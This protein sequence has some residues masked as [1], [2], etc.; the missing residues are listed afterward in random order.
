M[1]D[2]GLEELT[3][4]LVRKEYP[5]AKL[6]GSGRDG[7]IDVVSDFSRPPARG[8]QSKTSSSG[9]ASWT[10]CRASLKAA[11]EGAF[12][13]AHYTYVFSHRLSEEQRQ[14]WLDEFHP[15]QTAK[16]P[17]LEVLDYW[18]DLASRVEAFPEILDWIT[19]G[20]LGA[21]VRHTLELAT[22]GGVNPLASAVD[23]SEGARGVA[24]HAQA[25]G[26]TDPRFAY[27]VTGREAD[28]ADRPLRNRVARF[29][30][31][32]SD[33]DALPRFTLSIRDGDA[34]D[35][36]T[37][38]PRSG[39]DV[40]APQPWFADTE[41]GVRAR[42]TA[43][44]SLARGRA[45]TLQGAHVGIAGGHI[46]DRFT[47]WSQAPGSG[48]GALEIGMSE[49]LQLTVTLTLS[50]IGT[51]AELVAM[52]QV[53]PLPGARLGYAGAVGGAVVAIDLRDAEPPSAVG[54]TEAGGWVEALFSVTLAVQDES[55]DDA[56]RGLGLARAFAAAD[57]M[58]FD[59][60]GLLPTAG[61]DVEGQVPMEREASEI[62]EVA[63]TVA[64]ALDALQQRDGRARR[65]PEAVTRR[66]V[67]RAE[68]VLDLLRDG[69]IRVDVGEQFQ[70][71]LPPT[72]TL[73]DNLDR[74]QRIVAELPPIA[75]QLTG[76]QVEQTVE[77]AE[78]VRITTTDHGTLA[79]E[80]RAT[81]ARAQM[82]RCLL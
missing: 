16:Y 42:A 14:F 25:I 67:V 58:H 19:D 27:G 41:G 46:P 60:P 80:Y 78:P 56:M 70:V 6:T 73:D 4:R 62:W 29:T 11:M 66:D 20:A 49:P 32:T 12:P 40:T 18:D 44:A 69:E 3:L 34:V 33:R 39:V 61:Y 64:A 53:P 38:A 23:L 43:R 50:D 15:E 28:A 68:A 82:I 51:I 22:A 54:G 47:E 30:M 81:S 71:A 2:D 59:C 76:L 72:A 74:W 26:Q 24:E 35:Q 36:I 5:D 63:A 13:P 8:W 10:K 52:Y 75:G 1:G 79:L 65:M 57:R 48:S 31:T 9:K 55:V 37:A 77:D 7:G 21:Y 45:I 17:V